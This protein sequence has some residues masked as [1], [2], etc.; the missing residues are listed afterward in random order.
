M[1]LLEALLLRREFRRLD[2]QAEIIM[3]EKGA[4]MYRFQIVS[5]PF[6]LSGVVEDSKRLLMMTPESFESKYKIDARV[7][8]EVIAINRHEKSVTI[9]STQTGELS[10]EVYDELILSPGASPIVPNLQCAAKISLQK[11]FVPMYN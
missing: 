5:L 1:E 7:N 11:F 8:S 4:V 2:E 9:R 10:T 3:F 6:Y